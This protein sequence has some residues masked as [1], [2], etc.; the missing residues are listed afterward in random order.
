MKRIIIVTLVCFSVLE[1]KAQNFSS[2]FE[3]RYFTND[4]KANGETDFLGETEWMNT[5]QRINFL[6]EYSTVASAFFDN[7]SLDKK[8]VSDNEISDLLNKIK[9]Q[10]ITS[11]RK[12]IRLDNWKAYAYRKGQDVEKEQS[13]GKWKNFSGA[14]VK[15]GALMMENS[16]IDRVIDS[17]SW[18]FKVE[19]SIK[20][21][22]SSSCRI[23]LLDGNKQAIIFGIDGNKLIYGTDNIINEIEHKINDDWVKLKIEVD[24]TQKRFNL[25][26]DDERI[27]YFIPIMDTSI[28]AITSLSIKSV[29]TSLVN[30]IFIFNHTPT[31]QVRYPYVSKV[32]ID[33]DFQEK[34]GIDKWQTP[35]FNDSE[36][37][38]VKLPSVHGGMREKEEAYY[39]RKK[40]SLTIFKGRF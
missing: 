14:S 36:W 18:R 6:K 39:L 32:I 26:V 15:N 19:T 22:K 40:L 34:P 33:E 12:T 17:L 24:L 30:D 2:S 25:Y 16:T 21:E 3:M 5:G 20:S 11:V 10:P 29:G 27:Q 35:D 13:L 7:P 4:S 8:I 9:P 23:S 1:I 38:E 37:E 28:E 31:D